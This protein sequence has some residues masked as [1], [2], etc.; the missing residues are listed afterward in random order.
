MLGRGEGGGRR[1]EGK[2]H[3]NLSLYRIEHEVE[4]LANNCA[5]M[6]WQETC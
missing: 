1:M 2:Y 6:T 3:E 5:E 4:T